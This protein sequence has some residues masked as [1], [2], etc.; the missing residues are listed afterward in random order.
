ML[1]RVSGRGMKR[2]ITGIVALFAVVTLS[3]CASG[4][5]EAEVREVVGEYTMSGPPG[6]QGVAGARGLPGTSGSQGT[7]GE[8]GMPGTSGPQGV[9]GG[10]GMQGETGLQGERG[11]QG[12][13]GERG[14]QGD[15]GLQGERGDLGPQG[16][17]GVPGERGLQ[18]EQGD[19]GERGERGFQGASAL[20]AEPERPANTPIPGPSSPSGEWLLFDQDEEDPFLIL[21]A[22]HTSGSEWDA[23]IFVT[24]MKIYDPPRFM[25]FVTWD[26]PFVQDQASVKLGWDNEAPTHEDVHWDAA[27]E[28]EG[29]TPPSQLAMGAFLDRMAESHH[30]EI[31]AYDLSLV[32]AKFSTTG[33]P[34]ALETI[35]EVCQ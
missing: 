34:E 10:R 15:A 24:C 32:G 29:I 20:P 18:G 31:S 27:I 30:L 7:A 28:G 8:R 22:Y 33:A 25:I 6:P 13:A 35:T 12:V 16:E 1:N 5:S 19:Q 3:A 4:L 2:E 26:T 23:A 11:P 14:P 9:A 17:P 21:H